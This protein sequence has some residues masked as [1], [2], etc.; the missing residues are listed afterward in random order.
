LNFFE[1]QD[2]ARRNTRMLVLLFIAAV[3]GLIVLTNVLLAGFL[4]FG[5]DYN[6]YSGNRD[7]LAGFISYFSWERFGGIGLAVTATVALVVMVKWIQLSTGGKA[8][9]ESMGGTRI[10]PQ[11]RDPGERR[12][13]NVVE[14]MA[15]AANMPVPPVYV[16]NG[17]RG[18]NAFAAGTTPADAVVAVTR[19]TI[20]QLKRHELQGVIAHEFSHIL[21]G[22]MR[23]NI[24]LAAMLKGITFVGDVGY[25][26]LH[27][28]R[29]SSARTGVSRS[30]GNKGSGASLVMLAL[31]LWLLGWLG[32]LAAGFIK[33][34]ISRQKEF[35]ADASAV[36]YTRTPEGI[37]DALRVIGGYL[38]GTL[39]HSAR[40]AEM[41][42]IFFGQIEHPLW[43]LFATHPP[44]DERIRRVN[45]RWDGTYLE[46][47]VQRYTEK[48]GA[49]GVGVGRAEVVAAALAS[50]ASA[51]HANDPA[52]A[53]HEEILP[54]AEFGA[55]PDEL[56]AETAIE[57]SLPIAFV[58]YSHDPFSANA[59]IFALLISPQEAVRQKQ[60]AHI[61]DA[62][63]SGLADLVLTLAPGV[64]ALNAAQRLPLLQ[65]CL[66]ALKAIS[67]PQYRVFK[68]TMMQIIQAD[69]RTDLYEWC[70]FQLVRHYLDPEFI[71]VKPS[72][73]R[74]RRF[75]KVRYHLRIVLSILAHEGSGEA[76]TT[77]S[78]AA[79]NLGFP[80]LTLML[81]EQCSVAGFSK[82]VHELADCYPLLKPK[83]LKAMALAAG[84]DGF[85]SAPELE[86][87]T[88]MAA[89]MDCPVPDLLSDI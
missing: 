40:A 37:G 18:I 17:E 11:T 83:L 16:M 4:W 51:T 55:S 67:A 32:G 66:P 42:H 39:V 12:C 48:P 45:P 1:Q 47:D 49:G 43:Q 22:D 74:Y 26:L 88:S 81:R 62:K 73:P 64:L 25:M 52:N 82:A 69:A 70:L 78:L 8:V 9:A 46:R 89:V 10:L 15:L 56:E 27:G 84:Y 24:R 23:L 28:S 21:N 79:T 50:A 5:Q 3:F 13:L 76:A 68:N 41:S 63:V 30:G 86:I 87:I 53:H 58:Q 59:L 20:A 14:E 38:P 36:Q 44:L 19:G 60:L 57:Q 77:F 31:A 54:D 72:R 7:G 65:M 34:G 75:D 29:S 61:K 6:L 85:L 35:L 33:S 80:A 71:R 2:I